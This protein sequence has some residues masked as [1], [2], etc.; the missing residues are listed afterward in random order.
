MAVE[1]ITGIA[2]TLGVG[3]VAVFVTLYLSR[4]TTANQG[5]IQQLISKI[6]G[7]FAASQRVGIE[8]AY[9]NREI[10][11]APRIIDVTGSPAFVTRFQTEK[12]LIV[13]GA[14][15]LG[16]KMYV[17]HLPEILRSRIQRGFET[18]FMLT[19]PCFSR[20]R[21]D[22][23]GRYE[24][25]I[26]KEIEET[27]RFL[28]E[29]ALDTNE[30]VRFYRGT[31]TCF[32]IVTSNAMLVNP[33]PYQIEAFRSFC[34]EVRRLPQVLCPGS[35]P[36]RIGMGRQVPPQVDRARFEDEFRDLIQSEGEKEYDYSMDI[37]PDIYGQFYWFH[38][39]LPWFSRQAVTYSEFKSICLDCECLE[40]GYNKEKCAIR[41][42]QQ[43]QAPSHSEVMDTSTRAAETTKVQTRDEDA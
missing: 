36:G 28:E 35:P 24:G 26:R 30:S 37:G 9:E 13:V 21:E 8:T 38:Y 7:L 40:H 11:L 42:K 25:Q 29:C 14:S 39:L 34:L 43:V 2:I 6:T 32:V 19:H 31:P 4:Q 41:T 17:Q 15:L 16:F 12:K 27:A 22:Q 1:T 10:A 5:Q 18:K 20:L 3:L 33:Y 23:E